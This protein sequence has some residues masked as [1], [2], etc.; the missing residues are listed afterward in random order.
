MPSTHNENGSE[1]NTVRGT[2]L[3]MVP[4]T[5]SKHDQS[6]TQISS[7]EVNGRAQKINFPSNLGV[8]LRAK[9]LEKGGDYGGNLKL[10]HINRTQDLPS[11][12]RDL[13]QQGE[14]SQ[15]K[16]ILATEEAFSPRTSQEIPEQ[17]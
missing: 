5:L 16:S 11:C 2:Q 7:P 10:G 1:P 15:K 12:S 14:T 9:N 13:K 4:I 8:K 6:T 3:T 17:G